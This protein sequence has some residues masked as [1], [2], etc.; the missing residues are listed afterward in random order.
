MLVLISAIFLL[1]LQL[2]NG[3]ECSCTPSPVQECHPYDSQ[4]Q[5]NNLEEAMSS[6]P[7]LSYTHLEHL[8]EE[9][10]EQECS[11]Q[12]CL[13]CRKEIRKKLKRLGLISTTINDIFESQSNLTTCQKYRFARRD[14][15]GIVEKDADQ[16]DSSSHQK[17]SEEEDNSE[18]D[19]RE[20]GS[21][22]K[23]RQ[24]NVTA[25]AAVI[26]TRYTMSCTTKGVTVDAEGT[27]SLCTACWVWRKLPANYNPSYINELICDNGDVSCLSG[28]AGCS[29]G[30]RQLT[31]VRNVGGVMTTVSITAGSSCDC[32]VHKQSSIISL[33]Q[34]HGMT[35]SLSPIN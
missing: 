8:A 29:T 21:K 13:D 12:Q 9:L 18:E 11:T 10:K 22:R 1:I 33:V 34:G 31:A 2:V 28:Y 20:K 15:E 17:K 16:N 5:A 35:S 7:D 24:T 30:T 19:S 14:E 23:K 25:A 32:R 26:G 4:F 6:F 3:Q 27:V